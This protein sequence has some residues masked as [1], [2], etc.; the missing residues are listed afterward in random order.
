VLIRERPRVTTALDELGK[1]SETGTRLIDESQPT[2]YNLQNLQARG[3]S[4]A[5][6]GPDLDAALAFV[7]TF[8]YS[9][10]WSTERCV[11]T[12]SACRS[13]RPHHP[14]LRGPCSGHALGTTRRDPDTR[15]R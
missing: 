3:Q 2:W 4:L 13:Y 6:I 7:T 10:A 11:G 5:D 14:R 12:T 15:T 1:L 9:G 8:P